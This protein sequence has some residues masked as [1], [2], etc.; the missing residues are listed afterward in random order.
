MLMSWNPPDLW[1]TVVISIGGGFLASLVLLILQWGWNTFGERRRRKAAIKALWNFFHAW[2][3]AVARAA[4]DEDWQFVTHEQK[5]RRIND[6]L[7]LMRPNLYA[8]Q[9]SEITEFIRRQGELIDSKRQ[10]LSLAFPEL[11][12]D[13]VPPRLILLP[14]EYRNFF[15][16]ARKIKWL[17]PDKSKARKKFDSQ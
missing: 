1:A 7:T 4:Y 11:S 16:Q 3:V 17:K 6:L 8:S 9:S 15:E 12:A 5:L 2:D 13:T 10:A 14:C